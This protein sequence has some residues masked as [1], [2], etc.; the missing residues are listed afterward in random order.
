MWTE[1]ILISLSLSQNKEKNIVKLIINVYKKE[2][3]AE[4]IMQTNNHKDTLHN[5]ETWLTFYGTER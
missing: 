3:S 5:G 2:Q 1:L 4:N